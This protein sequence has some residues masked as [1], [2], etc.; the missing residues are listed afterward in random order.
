LSSRTT[1]ELLAA[2]RAAP[3]DDAPRLVYADWLLQ[4]SDTD[5]YGQFIM[6]QCRGDEARERALWA[7]HGAAWCAR[8]GLPREQLRFE[9]GFVRQVTLLAGDDWPTVLGCGQ[10]VQ[11]LAIRIGGRARVPRASLEALR[12][13]LPGSPLRRLSV[14]G[15]ALYVDEGGYHRFTEPVQQILQELPARLRALEVHLVGDTDGLLPLL[16]R[17]DTRLQELSWSVTGGEI[18]ELGEVLRAQPELHSLTLSGR[19]GRAAE[20]LLRWPGLARLRHLGWTWAPVDED[21]LALLLQRVDPQLPSLS[22]TSAGGAPVV[23][24]T[25]PLQGLRAL[26]LS[27]LQLRGRDLERLAGRGSLSALQS[28][29][30]T[31]NDQLLARSPVTRRLAKGLSGVRELA[32]WSTGLGT[33]AAQELAD[34]GVLSSVRALE[35]ETDEPSRRRVDVAVLLP[36]LSSLESLR[37]QGTGATV[38]RLLA[39]D[40]PDRLRELR[41]GLVSRDLPALQA[42]ADTPF[43][44]LR[45]FS[46]AAPGAHVERAVLQEAPWWPALEH[47]RLL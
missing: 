19:T 14:G 1:T 4:Q 31:D 15:Q 23:E 11:E 3:D 28:L 35:I 6:A 40:L 12:T 8:I 38:R 24:A 26:R 43:P 34:G 21:L 46:L 30:L 47:G 44:R 32:L 22:L 5:P 9:R 39:S 29:D 18:V 33:A 16:A 42:L 41:I 37:L 13:W 17:T 45:H 36:H 2:V 27:R 20:V 10:P 25:A 7:A